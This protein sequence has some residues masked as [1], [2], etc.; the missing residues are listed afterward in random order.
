MLQ[1]NFALFLLFFLGG[2]FLSFTPV[3]PEEN[4][5]KRVWLQL[6]TLKP[7][8][9]SEY[10]T[11]DKVVALAYR[12]L[13]TPYRYGGMQEGGFDCSGFVCY[14]YLNA[15]GKKLP[16]NAKMQSRYVQLYDLKQLEKGDLVFFDTSGKGRIN[17]VGIYLGNGKFI[18]ASSGKAYGVTVSDLRKGFYKKA[19]RWGGK[20]KQW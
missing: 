13:G 9:G 2:C 17:H 19:F 8:N 12:Q 15:V 20:V 4:I 6:P 1:I 10:S 7:E 5:T 18:H 11:S 14:V 16:H 3:S